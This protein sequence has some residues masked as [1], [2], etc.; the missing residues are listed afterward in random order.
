MRFIDDVSKDYGY[1][2][3]RWNK[4]KDTVRDALWEVAS[5]ES[6]I[7]YGDTARLIRSIID[8]DPHDTVFH[9]MLGQISIEE[10]R[11]GRGMLSALVVHKEGDQIPGPGFFD[12]AKDLNRDTTDPVTFW[13]EE[14]KRLYKEAP[15]V[16]V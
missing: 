9:H 13:I 16:R 14:V 4:T 8:F 5:R 12:L 1:G 2:Q 11:A 10:N 15:S 3:A 7:T 6:Q